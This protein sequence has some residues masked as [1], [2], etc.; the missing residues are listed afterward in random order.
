MKKLSIFLMML[1]FACF[2]V[3]KAQTLT[4]ADG[5]ATN[6]YI[7]V[8][9]YYA[10]TDG[11]N[12]EFIV[13]AADLT[14][15]RGN[16]IT[17]MDFYLSQA[18]SDSWGANFQ[19]YL[20]EMS[21]TT[22]SENYGP[23][24]FTVV[25]TGALDGT[26]TTMHVEFSEPY[27]Y[28]G[29]NLLVGTYVASSG[30]Y[31]RAYFYGV[32]ATG[33]AY[34]SYE[35]WSSVTGDVQDFI[36][37]TTFTY[38]A[39]PACPKPTGVTATN[40]TAHGAT[41]S[42]TGSSDS[43]ILMLGQAT[44]LASYDFESNS[45]PAAFTNS[46]FYPWTVVANTHSGAYCAK[47]GNAGS[48]S[49]TSDLVLQV[50]LT[51][52]GSVS[53]SAMASSEQN[54]DWG[55]F[56]IDDAQQFQTSGTS[57]SWTDYSFDLAAGSHT[58]TWRFEK[59]GSSASGDDCFYVDDIKIN[60][61]PTTWDETHTASASPYT[62]TDL[63]P[64]TSYLVMVKG[65]CDGEQGE[66][67]AAVSFTT[68][69][70]CAT[71]QNLIVTTDGA[72]A[73]A[74][75]TGTEGTCNIDI[76][77]TVTN[78]VTSPYTFN[79][80]LSTTYTV[81]VQANCDGE[82]S[83]WSA[84][85]SFTTPACVGGHIIEYTLNDSYGD[86]WNGASI[87][88]IEGC[89][90][91]TL[92][93]SGSSA[94]G[95]LTICA[96]YF[97]FVWNTGSYDS[98]CGFT[99]TE[100]GT[101]LFTKPSSLSDGQVLYTFGTQTMPKPTGL[102]AGTP[103]YDNVNLSWTENGT[104][105]AWEICIN[106]NESNLV[107]A[108]TNV[109]F[110]LTGLQP[111]NSYSIKVRAVSE[112]NESCWS[113]EV[114]VTTSVACAKPTDLTEANIAFTTAD[115]SWTGTANSYVAEYG[116]WTQVGTD[117][118]ATE[119]MTPYTF[120]LSGFSGNGVVAIRHYN[121]ND[122]FRVNVDD[123]VVRDA[124]GNIVYSE[125][126]ESSSLP[127]NMSSIDLDGDGKIWYITD[128]G[129]NGAYG[130]TSASWENQVVLYPDNW[131]V[132][133]D[134]TLGGSITFN[135]VGQ[136]ASAPAEVF[137]VF[138][139]AD[140]QFTQTY[141]GTSTSCQI[142]GLTEGTAYA[143]RV[144]GDCG[145]YASNWAFSMFKTADDLL[146]FA[147]E[148]NWNDLSN[149]T[150]IDGNAATALPTADNKVRI[151]A[152]AL[153]PA[154]VVA[155]AKNATLNGG[156]IEIEDGGQLKQGGS[157]K[158]TMHKGIDGYGDEYDEETNNNS[159]YYFIATPHNCSYFEENS[160]FPYVLNVTDGEYD[161]YAFDPTQELEWI[162]YKSSSSHTEFHQGDNTGLFNKK[163]YLYANQDDTDL[164][165]VGTV[166]SSLNNILTESFTYNATSADEFNGWKLV[167]NPYTCDA[168]ISYVD[169]NGNALSADFYTMNN[170]N[171]YTLLT[172]SDPLAPLT[173]ALINFSATGTVQFASEAP[174][175]TYGKN[176]GMI[177]MNLV[178]GN[179]TV[180]QARVRFGQGFN[181]QHMSFRN[182]SKIYMPVDN[183]EYAV[184][185]TEEQ[186]EMPVCFKAENNG[187][188][189]INFTTEEVSFG[190]LHLID[191][192]NGNDV[193][194]LQTPS[195]TFEAKT[196]DYESR[197]KLVFA[198]GNNDDNFAFFSNGS[199]V[200]NNEGNATLQ[201][202][203]INGRILKSES[204]NGCANVN[205]NAAQGIYML[206]LVN[207]NDVKVQK[208]VVR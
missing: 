132:I 188:Y 93:C 201:V 102:T 206:R 59:D 168:Y 65:V 193:D 131:L 28:N 202:I 150:D 76:N 1:C 203:D 121:V 101:T 77:G 170:S 186:G 162:N 56:L 107:P 153:I 195:Y 75:W 113:D 98:E 129:I 5:T 142:T 50:N 173:G 198:T 175:P 174:T 71:P 17:A 183:N 138:V 180:D 43:Y 46:A 169:G 74:T 3:A 62:F 96:D 140:N 92:T 95:T 156:S 91:T 2:G 149:W 191:N 106:G 161:L 81:K 31:K 87:T 112:N 118:T 197:F 22:L 114:T 182:N 83:G 152:N 47:S 166:S 30:S 37:K 100:G 73:T 23:D 67:S 155:T 7:P 177:N 14:A 105:T 10:D 63:D 13:P 41:V 111:D 70:S 115:L 9:G 66:P 15:M 32:A 20:G 82:T 24:D 157:V 125:N 12:S 25:Y 53:F 158:V 89:E 6:E 34:Y 52:A 137:G 42:W 60:M 26:G 127:G 190:Y 69:E 84:P 178:R 208:V 196:T 146:I 11:C 86:G 145:Q 103:S 16:E 130:V 88:F 38:Q 172:S 58:L 185:Y 120:S 61:N 48:N 90:Q 165:F 45:I 194:L 144:Q 160:V 110:N 19:V 176:F 8:Y 179:K 117:Q 151:D 64:E 72:T 35:G 135:A 55:R 97:E 78:N 189:T 68:L 124:N 44:S 116:I 184:V 134:I 29:G 49:S 51:N 143:W 139:I 21:G 148:G 123:I 167:G 207:G 147:T 94:S 108:N 181:M 27:T 126:F 119:T 36:P 109:D 192:M 80:E 163:G 79:V 122:Q 136:D 199:F 141:S 18:A 104:A 85:F 205:V 99:F 57:N 159:N 204:I 171:T 54:W 4:V 40:P 164:E 154:G 200:I 39:P 128:V 133:S 33:A 187:T